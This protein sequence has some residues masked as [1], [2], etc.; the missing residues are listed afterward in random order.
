[1]EEF[2]RKSLFVIEQSGWLAPVFFILLH[3]IRQIFFIPVLFICLLG[4]YLF[5]TLAGS[6][7]SIIGLTAVSFVFYWLVYLF[8]GVRKKV[9]ALKRRMLKDDYRLTLPQMMVMR[10]M[11]FVHFHLVSLYLMETTNNVKK[12]TQ[13][14]LIVSIPPAVV[15]TSFGDMLHELPLVGTMVFA[16]FL[17]LLFLFFRQKRTTSVSWAGFFAEKKE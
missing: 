13:Q 15:Y 6:L 3:V 12:Y 8:P 7:Y 5:G 1:M 16:I 4:G 14:S 10:L 2:L 11:P 17:A 9:A